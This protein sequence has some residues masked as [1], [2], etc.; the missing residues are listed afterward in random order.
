MP[1]L[2][3]RVG[4]PSKTNLLLLASASERGA[5]W[6][7]VLTLVIADADKEVD[8]V[9]DMFKDLAKKKKKKSSKPKEGED[10][11]PAADGEFD[12]SALKKKKKK[13]STKVSRVPHSRLRLRCLLTNPRPAPMTSKPNLQ[14]PTRP[15][16]KQRLMLLLSQSKRVT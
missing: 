1:S 15:R 8:E 3:P 4:L 9:T 2:T 14:R 13:K 16:V 11:A 12:P 7:D 5:V 6:M 10:E